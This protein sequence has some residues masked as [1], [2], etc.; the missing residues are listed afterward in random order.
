MPTN[1]PRNEDGAE[2]VDAFFTS[3]RTFSAQ[4]AKKVK[5]GVRPTLNDSQVRRQPRADVTHELGQKGRQVSIKSLGVLLSNER[6]AGR[7]A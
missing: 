7:R 6:L 4:S 3:P 5:A 2:D 1:V